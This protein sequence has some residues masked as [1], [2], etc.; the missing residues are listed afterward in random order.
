MARH[1]EVL[2]RR[3]VSGLDPKRAKCFNPKTIKDHLQL[4]SEI[5]PRYKMR[6]NWDETNFNQ[7]AGRRNGHKV[8][9][10]IDDPAP[11]RL[12]SGNL[13]ST[14][15]MLYCCDDG[16]MLDPGLLFTGTGNWWYAE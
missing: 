14:T 1:K 4:W 10:G 12:H 6:L 16:T 13:R 3:G 11:S 9:T 2:K 5:A 8:Y 7:A 15:I